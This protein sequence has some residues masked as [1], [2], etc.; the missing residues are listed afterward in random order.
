M[1]FLALSTHS[2]YTE[3]PVLRIQLILMKIR[4]QAKN[5]NQKL[6]QKNRTVQ[7][8][9][10]LKMSLSLNGSSSWCRKISEQK[11][12]ILIRKFFFLSKKTVNLR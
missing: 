10:L 11:T 3:N 8:K 9:K 4:I 7:K 5:I 1:K 2:F 12:R 6:Q